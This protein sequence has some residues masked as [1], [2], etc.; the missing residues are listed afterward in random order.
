V[1]DKP[2]VKIVIV[3]GG[4]AGWLTAAILNRR[5]GALAKLTLVESPQISTI[6]VGEATQPN[7]GKTLRDLDVDEAEFMKR[8][9]ASFKHGILFNSWLHDPAE[10]ANHYYHMFDKFHGFDTL[11]L[12][13][14]KAAA[15][16]FT[17]T[18]APDVTSAWLRRRSKGTAA[19]YAYETGIQPFLCDRHKAPRSPEMPPYDG[20]VPYAY[21]LDADQLG[22]FLAELCLERGVERIRAHVSD[23]RTGPADTVTGLA[24]QDGRAIEADL[25]VDCTGFRSALLGKALG[26]PFNSYEDVMLCN[27]AAALQIPHDDP[28]RIRPYTTSTALPAGWCWEID[29]QGRTGT[30]YVYGSRFIS[31]DEAAATLIAHLGPRAEGATPRIIPFRPGHRTSM[32]KGNVVG[33]GLAAGFLEPLESPGIY[34]IEKGAAL[35]AELLPGLPSPTVSEQFNRKMIDLF[36]EIRDFLVLHY[37][38]SKR[39][40]SP[41]W[42]EVREPLRAPEGLRAKLDEW[43]Q[44]A[45]GPLDTTDNWLCFWYNSYRSVLFG[46]DWLPAA[47]RDSGEADPTQEQADAACAQLMAWAADQASDV[48][49]RH[50]EAIAAIIDRKGAEPDSP[51]AR[52]GR[53]FAVRL[54]GQHRRPSIA[55]AT[56]HADRARPGN[57]DYE[58][59]AL[60]PLDEWRDADDEELGRWLAGDGNE[61]GYTIS[62][63]R[64][65]ADIAA[66]LLALGREIAGSPPPGQRV[67][68]T[69]GQR[70]VLTEALGP[71]V[72]LYGDPSVPTRALGA[73]FNP[74]GLATTTQGPDGRRIGLHVD[75]WTQRPADER[76]TA[77]N[78]I[79]INIGAG[80]RRLVF[81]PLPLDEI[82]AG[83][84]A[85]RGE[86]ALLGATDIARIF[87]RSH[88]DVPV[89]AVTVAPGE[90]YIAPTENMVHDGSTLFCEHG[91]LIATYLGRFSDRPLRQP[92]PARRAPETAAQRS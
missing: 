32:W 55:P 59:S 44:R 4:T 85:S 6:G 45:P 27:R 68:M 76:G 35:L 41:F 57:E 33:I 78:R 46:M 16:L 75:S 63:V 31:D 39:A 48:L 20:L 58:I 80:P 73:A 92:P 77:Q 70:R 21:H 74:S 15:K 82:V 5:L 56:R 69:P 18:G 49:P 53:R 11:K 90:A 88:P 2:P 7:F 51:P 36:D 72:R 30:G 28:P 54:A 64:L 61:I 13:N 52:A 84:G 14:L 25:F 34:L 43:R 19:P 10:T 9:D 40:D 22:V 86:L 67:A 47:A 42:R 29:L 23:V 1:N 65:P 87:M 66:P 3:G 79:C 37:Y 24:T 89:L 60:V 12:S 38:I 17:G 71:L 8:T 91:D 50:E 62:V 83:L 81:L 26:T